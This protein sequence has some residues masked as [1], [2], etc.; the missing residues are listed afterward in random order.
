MLVPPQLLRCAEKE[1][2]KV[3][4]HVEPYEGRNAA[5]LRRD[6]EYASKAYGGHPA[7]QKHKGRIVYYLCALYHSTE[8]ASVVRIVTFGQPC[9]YSHL[10][11]ALRCRYDSYREPA[12][13]WAK[14]FDP[15]GPLTVRNTD[16]DG[17]FL[18][19]LLDRAHLQYAVDAHC[20][21]YCE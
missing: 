13:E 18:C 10:R 8:E 2:L 3:A 9:L 20:D 6:V 12:K 14:L 1:G 16:M 4:L 21:G 17:A 15:S 11:L 5:T 19:L 7:M